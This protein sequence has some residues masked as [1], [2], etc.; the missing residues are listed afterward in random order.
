[1]NSAAWV[2]NQ[3]QDWKAN[4]LSKAEIVAKCASVCVGW[5]YVYGE[6]GDYCTPATRRKRANAA[7][8]KYPAE[9]AAI[10]SK[11][12]VLRG[13]TTKCSGCKFLPMDCQT[14]CFDCRG[15]THWVLQQVGIDIS[16]QGATS[17]WNTAGNW[18]AKGELKDLPEDRVCCL[19]LYNREKGTMD[20]T[21]LYIGGGLCCHCSGE[22][23]IEDLKKPKWTHWAIPKGLEG[24]VVPVPDIRPTLRNGSRGEYVYQLQ[25][26]LI[27]L[28]YDLKPYGA[29]GSFGN[30]T[31]A[32]VKAFQTDHGLQADG[33]CG[34]MTWAALE[35]AAAGKR[36]TIRIE[37]LTEYQKEALRQ[38]YPDAEITEEG[39]V[40]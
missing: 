19:F 13:G 17:Q 8:S 4:G 20:H 21:G 27:Q 39:S 38:L 1:M 25:E 31:A 35:T 26:A 15:F 24:G 7:E 11:C 34:P 33:V 28:G 18:E 22:V 9:A 2:D 36:Y 23:K 32:A 12:Q 3:V 40:G 37:H 29:D 5:D 14:R 30:K 6:W 10:R 16:G